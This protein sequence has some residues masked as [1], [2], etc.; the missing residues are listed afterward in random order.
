MNFCDEFAELDLWSTIPCHASE[1]KKAD[2]RRQLLAISDTRLWIDILGVA[3]QEF[4]IDVLSSSPSLATVSLA[5]ADADA[6]V[7]VGCDDGHPW[8][9]KT[10]GRGCLPIALLHVDL[11]CSCR[12]DSVAI[13]LH[14]K[15][16]GLDSLGSSLDALLR[17]ELPVSSG[18][19]RPSPLVDRPR[20][21]SMTLTSAQLQVLELISQGHSNAQIA[22]IRGTRVRAV[23]ALISRTFAKLEPQ[24][25]LRGNARVAATRAYLSLVS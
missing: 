9:T 3:A 23:E 22:A 18:D 4:G 21:S 15:N 24:I 2:T 11:T 8:L 12:H 16:G 20:R 7:A 19:S 17:G 13:R 25:S 6:V 10:G 1:V 14:P 5:A